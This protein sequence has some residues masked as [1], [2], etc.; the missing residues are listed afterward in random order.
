MRS[1]AIA[2]N[3]MQL[4]ENLA[5]VRSYSESPLSKS[6]SVK[7]LFWYYFA[8]VLFWGGGCGG[9]TRVGSPTLSGRATKGQKVVSLTTKNGTVSDICVSQRAYIL[10]SHEES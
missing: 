4:H 2:Q 7:R 9:S 1:H 6:G 10:A 5:I 8:V 3:C